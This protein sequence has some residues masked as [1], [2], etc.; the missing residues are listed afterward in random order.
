MRVRKGML[1]IGAYTA[2]GILVVLLGVVSSNPLVLASC[3]GSAW[4]T[5]RS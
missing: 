4:R 3:S 2:F 5:W 1:V